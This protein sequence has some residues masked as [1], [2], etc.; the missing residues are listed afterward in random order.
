MKT[1]CWLK[2]K[3]FKHYVLEVSFILFGLLSVNVEAENVSTLRSQA[4]DIFTSTKYQTSSID[5]ALQQVFHQQSILHP[6]LK[7]DSSKIN[8]NLHPSLN[9]SSSKKVDLSDRLLQKVTKFYA[10]IVDKIADKIDGSKD[11]SMNPSCSLIQ[12][13]VGNQLRNTVAQNINII[14]NNLIQSTNTQY[15]NLYDNLFNNN[16]DD[17]EEADN[18]DD[19]DALSLPTGSN[20]NPLFLEVS[21][22][23]KK[24]KQTITLLQNSAGK[25]LASKEDLLNW[26]VVIPQNFSNIKFMDQEYYLLDDFTGTKYDVDQ[27]EMKANVIIPGKFFDEQAMSLKREKILATPSALGGYLNY[28][29]M[30]QRNDSEPNITNLSGSFDLNVFKGAWVLNNSFASYRTIGSKTVKEQDASSSSTSASSTNSADTDDSSNNNKTVRL[31]SSWIYDDPEE[32]RT[33]IVGDNFSSSAMWGS[34]VGFGGIH[35]GS[36]F[37]TQPTFDTHPLPS[38]SGIATLPSTVELYV[39]NSLVSRKDVDVGPFDIT[40]IPLVNGSGTLSVVTTDILGRQEVIEMPYYSSGELLKPDLHDYAFDAGFVRKNYGNDNFNYGNFIAVGK[41]RKGISDNYT[42]ELRGEFSLQQ[43]AIGY[44]GTFI[45]QQFGVVD[46]SSAISHGSSRGIGELASLGFQRSALDSINYG[47]NIEFST[48]QFGLISMDDK[49]LMPQLTSRA[50]VGVPLKELG[51]LSFTYT[52]QYT[53]GENAKSSNLLGVG[54]TKTLGKVWNLRVAS[55]MNIG[56]ES[57]KSISLSLSRSLGERMNGSFNGEWN[58]DSGIRKSLNISKGMPPSSGFG[59][60]IN[61]NQS[62]DSKNYQLNVSAQNNVGT[63]R[64]DVAESNGQRG[65]RLNTSGSLA[66]FKKHVAFGKSI[67]N[68]FALVQVPG[69]KDVKVYKSNNL[70]GKTNKNGD[71]FVPSLLPYQVNKIKIDEKDLPL[72]AKVSK[73]ELETVPYDRSGVI[74]KFPVQPAFGVMIKLL[75]ESGE[76]V[77]SGANVFLINTLT[78][79]EDYDKITEGQDINKKD[80]TISDNVYPV[81]D[82]GLVY[83]TDLVYGTNQLQARWDDEICNFTITYNDKDAKEATIPNLGSV[84]CINAKNSMSLVEKPATDTKDVL[85]SIKTTNITELP[86]KPSKTS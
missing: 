7:I 72:T 42:R 51:S 18:P 41:D 62:Q 52:Q 63:Y 9:S 75:T 60:G 38:T 61:L 57:N 13:E 24:L 1:L 85:D 69:Y 56:G 64:A 11:D 54:Y 68:S 47:G 17:T 65:C 46:F 35:I 86:E 81:A 71:A 40:S 78:N 16:T 29:L 33:I 80:D 6:I 45:W 19:L 48:E 66:W 21:L 67:Y 2:V 37:S 82:D 70:V 74:V 25:L 59:Y 23:Y 44:S 39:N 27:R 12:E 84:T 28:D 83:I 8:T 34:S 79:D 3:S 30:A 26:G 4:E 43:Q 55:I 14:N 49:T 58:K 32:M 5:H 15:N 10:K 77:P 50:F 73:V 20:L 22:N 31:N 36:D 76:I 53:R